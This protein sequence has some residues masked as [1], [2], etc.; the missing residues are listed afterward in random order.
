MFSGGG[1]LEVNIVGDAVAHDIDIE[2][3]GGLVQGWRGGGGDSCLGGGG[4]C[5]SWQGSR[6]HSWRGRCRP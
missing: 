3:L 2:L 5:R 1:Q 6:R 4:G